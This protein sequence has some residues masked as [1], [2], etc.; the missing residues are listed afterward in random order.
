MMLFLGPSWL[1]EVLM[2]SPV[3]EMT[4]FFNE[5]AE[6]PPIGSMISPF[7]FK[8]YLIAQQNERLLYKKFEMKLMGESCCA[9]VYP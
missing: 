7:K 8:T 3:D 9:M 2:P 6:E 5:V 1:K 4:K